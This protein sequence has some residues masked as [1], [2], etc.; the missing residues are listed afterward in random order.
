MAVSFDAVG[1]GVAQASWGTSTRTWSHTVAS[2]NGVAVLVGIFFARGVATNFTAINPTSVTFGGQAMVL[3]AATTSG[4]GSTSSGWLFVY[5]LR[6]PT[7]RGTQTVSVTGR[8]TSVNGWA[9]SVSYDGVSQVTTAVLGNGNSGNPNIS[10]PTAVDHTVVGFLGILDRTVTNLYG[11]QRY[12]QSAGS[13]TILSGVISD[14]NWFGSTPINLQVTPSSTNSWGAV[15]IDLK[16]LT[17][18]DSSLTATATTSAALTKTVRPSSSGVTAIATTTAGI[19]KTVNA[20]AALTATAGDPWNLR[21]FQGLF[22]GYDLNG[23]P[24]TPN[25]SSVGSGVAANTVVSAARSASLAISTRIGSATTAT[26]T[27]LA[28][29][30]RTA[31]V[32]ASTTVVADRGAGAG[33]GQFL[34]ASLSTTAATGT[35]Q[36]L[37]AAGMFSSLFANSLLSATGLRTVIGVA[38]LT[39]TAARSAAITSFGVLN[40]SIVATAARTANLVSNQRISS[41][42]IGTA[43]AGGFLSRGQSIADV[44]V[45]ATGA[46]SGALSYGASAGANLI[47]TAL[48]SSSIVKIRLLSG[49]LTVTASTSAGL[50]ENT[51]AQATLTAT[52]TPAAALTKKLNA[53]SSLTATATPSGALIANRRM[54]AALTI[55]SFRDGMIDEPRE[56]IYVESDDR[57][58]TVELGD[59]RKA[60]IKKHDRYA[61]VPPNSD[62]TAT[63]DTTEVSR[64]ISRDALEGFRGAFFW[65]VELPM[66]RSSSRSYQIDD[67]DRFVSID[68]ADRDALVPATRP[69][70]LLK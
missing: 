5:S 60:F 57:K 64:A 26:A 6:N 68:A 58:A 49:S 16:D 32:S 18:G 17:L 40:A 48:F 35:P 61:A 3:E 63:V 11:N 28:S 44:G 20:G 19:T 30:T 7:N 47:S 29:E 9:N 65:F 8:L 46:R 51:V 21:N 38:N 55:I 37:Y 34:S 45:T 62:R 10:I 70:S 67:D 24:W 13:G 23:L 59:E 43:V 54:Q 69:E 4:G 41:G 12:I 1:G 15:G 39:S 2:G 42:I 14:S 33:R 50:V 66:I 52:A 53:A 27:F 56:I 31:T 36:T 22:F 25:R